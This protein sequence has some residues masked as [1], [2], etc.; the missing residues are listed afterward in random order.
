MQNMITHKQVNKRYKHIHHASSLHRS[1]QRVEAEELD[2]ALNTST[3]QPYQGT[4]CKTCSQTP[5]SSYV[6]WYHS[7]AYINI[8]VLPG[9]N[10]SLHYALFIVA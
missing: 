4:M 8:N 2:P 5:T 10:I 1:Q 7:T 6:T 9:R 3:R